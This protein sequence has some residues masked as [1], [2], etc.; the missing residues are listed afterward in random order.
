MALPYEVTHAVVRTLVLHTKVYLDT[1][2]ELEDLLKTD[3]AIKKS[4]TKK[5]KEA[6]D[7]LASVERFAVMNR[8]TGWVATPEWLQKNM[9]VGPSGEPVYKGKKGNK[10]A[11]VLTLKIKITGKDV[12]F[13]LKP[14]TGAEFRAVRCLKLGEGQSETKLASMIAGYDHL[15]EDDCTV[16]EQPEEPVDIGHDS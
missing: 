16:A 4:Q 9:T 7:G 10:S 14:R 13:E 5:L 11:W 1:K 8:R 12:Y 6:M 3:P 15:L 2:T